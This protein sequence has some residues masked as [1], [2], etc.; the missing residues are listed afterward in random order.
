MLQTRHLI[1]LILAAACAATGAPSEQRFAPL[2]DEAAWS[3]VPRETPPLPL[4]ARTLIDS[5]PR[6]TALQLDLDS[7]HRTKNPIGQVLAGRLR[8]AVAD[9]NRCTYAKESAETD[10]A[11]AGLS[12]EELQDLDEM[13]A[14]PEEER[15]AVAFA[16]KLTLAGSS[17]S[18]QEV[19]ELIAVYGPDD[20]VAIVHTVAHANF[21]NRLFLALGLTSEPD[22]PLPPREVRPTA[23][24]N[25]TVPD[26]L[27]QGEA[28]ASDTDG[29][30]ARTAWSERTFDELRDMLDRQRTRTPRIPKPDQVRL[31]RLPRP[32]R[33]RIAG[34]TWGK[35]SMGYQPVLT[36]AWFQ[37][38]GAFER[39]AKLDE[40]FANS[41]FWVVTRSNDCFY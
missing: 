18:D 17:I 26:R 33:E 28:S 29:A 38:M 37:T 39:E 5:L 23:D 6:T 22:G 7:L 8:W 24:T 19:A 31:A 25:F 15:I 30:D 40:V 10:L 13:D 14:P 2:S 35:V 34:T 1:P 32:D 41:V 36:G 21:Q 9:A 12:A 27:A 11:K 4:W 20:V 16:R 3:R